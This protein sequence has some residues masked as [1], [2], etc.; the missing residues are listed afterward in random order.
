MFNANQDTQKSEETGRLN[1]CFVSP[2]VRQ[3]IFTDRDQLSRWIDNQLALLELKYLEFE[4][5]SSR[6]GHFGR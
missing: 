2:K 6:R 3:P 1:E 5:S 4:T